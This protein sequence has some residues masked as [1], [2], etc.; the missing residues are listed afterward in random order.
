MVNLVSCS[1]H[2]TLLIT[3]KTLR[4]LSIFYFETFDQMS[5]QNFLLGVEGVLTLRT[6]I[7]DI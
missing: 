1:E 4:A 6:S 5:T 3:E 7:I 2:S